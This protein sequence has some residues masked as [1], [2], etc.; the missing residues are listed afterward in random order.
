MSISFKAL[1]VDAAD[2]QL[3]EIAGMIYDTDPYIY[4]AMFSSREEAIGVIPSM[5]RSGDGMFCPGNTYTAE[6][7]GHTVGIVLWH[8]GPLEWETDVYARCGGRSA[9]IG[10]ARD[11]YFSAYRNVPAGTVSLINVCVSGG[12]RGQ[13]IGGRML[14]AFLRVVPGPYELYVLADNRN[15]IALYQS[16]GFRITDELDGFSLE[17]EKPRCYKME[18][19]AAPAA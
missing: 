3:R 9:Y 12:M 5:I 1:G 14:D 7:Q 18:K 4:P 16:R 8:R 11:S 17:A 19:S 2:E 13:G 15:A 6:T 10:K